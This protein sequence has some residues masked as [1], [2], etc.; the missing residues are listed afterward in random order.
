MQNKQNLYGLSDEHSRMLEM[1]MKYSLPPSSL[2]KSLKPTNLA[3]YTSISSSYSW[4]ENGKK[5]YAGNV[6]IND[7]IILQGIAT[8]LGQDE[9][10][11]QNRDNS[12]ITAEIDGVKY[13]GKKIIVSGK[14]ITID[15]IPAAQPSPL[16][17]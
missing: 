4:T 7:R 15:D 9:F 13:S 5:M 8:Q 12:V 14:N 1:S 3:N 10:L 6:T 17:P 2:F 11:L 16:K